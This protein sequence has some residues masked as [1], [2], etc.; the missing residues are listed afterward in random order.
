ME[1]LPAPLS[2]PESEA[3]DAGA[4]SL[5][6][7]Q[8][9]PA[10][11]TP[12]SALALVRRWEV[13]LTPA[14][15]KRLSADVSRP[16]FCRLLVEN[17]LLRD[18]RTFLAH[19][20]PKRRALW[21]SC[22][23]ALDVCDRKPPRLEDAVEVVSRFVSSPNEQR[24][25]EAERFYRGVKPTSMAGMLSMAAFC[26]AGS[27]APVN[28]IRPVP[29]KPYVTARLAGTVVYL[30]ATIKDARQYKHHLRQYVALGEE[31]ARGRNLWQPSPSGE[32]WRLDAVPGEHPIEGPHR[33]AGDGASLASLNDDDARSSAGCWGEGI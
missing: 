30:A 12:L 6:V 33:T 10:E 32:I 29:A 28:S 27:I 2:L 26:S 1:T 23:C 24:R 22:L 20:L 18:A 3:T 19:A 16:A 5:D 9:T 21:W 15:Q 7:A 17:D 11:T 8:P 25:R 4:T 13:P 14:A 31:I